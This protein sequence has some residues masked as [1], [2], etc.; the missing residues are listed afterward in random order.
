MGFGTTYKSIRVIYLK[1]YLPA[2]IN[3]GIEELER[4][5][6]HKQE[7][8][9]DMSGKGVAAEGCLCDKDFGN[10]GNLERQLLSPDSRP[11]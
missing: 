6:S 8:A 4:T 5:V 2:S 10:A 7:K 9:F 1:K 11:Q 3:K